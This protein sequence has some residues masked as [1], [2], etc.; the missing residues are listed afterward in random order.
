MAIDLFLLSV[1]A[2]F[3][4]A[5]GVV[6]S[7]FGLRHLS[8]LSGASIS[9]PT[10][11]VFFLAASTV[12]VDWENWHG[13]AALVFALAGV[14]YPAAV[15]LLNFASN[16]LLGPDFSAA[17]GNLTPVFAIAL[18]VAI[19]GE[20]PRLAQMI[21][22]VV[23][24]AGLFLMAS[25]RLHGNS[26]AHLWLFGIPLAGALFRGAAQPL[27]K[28]GFA[29]WP[30]AFAAATI[31]YVVSAAMV[32]AARTGIRRKGTGYNRRGIAWFVAIG[33]TNGLALLSLY[34]ALSGGQVA[35]V[36]PVV[37][38]FPL[39]TY[40]LN[41]LILRRRTTSTRGIVG[42]AVSVCGVV[43]LLAL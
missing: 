4:M 36:A 41:R 42:I 25:E 5:L 14:F 3:L 6:L 39:F 10:S 20:T 23:V 16:R 24:L 2:A 13:Q 29:D 35:A 26:A 17:M 11:A 19:L 8:S 27:V 18:A 21:G 32:V 43:L 37:A 33:L 40:A 15:T 22:L 34:A 12:L 9:L 7:Q 30:S 28:L 38:T 1:L 31:S